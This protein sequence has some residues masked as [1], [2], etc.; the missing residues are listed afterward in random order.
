MLRV[1]PEYLLATALLSCL[2]TI[3][4]VGVG[5]AQADLAATAKGICGQALA[6]ALLQQG[7]SWFE[8]H[9]NP[10]SSGPTIV[11]YRHLTDSVNTF[12]LGN[13]DKFNGL[14]FKGYVYFSTDAYRIYTNGAWSP[15]KDPIGPIFRCGPMTHANGQWQNANSDGGTMSVPGDIYKLSASAVPPL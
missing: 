2:M 13:A 15:W 3:G 11:Q 8:G 10:N 4:P 7:D 14:D 9:R 6:N 5:R 12:P 1:N